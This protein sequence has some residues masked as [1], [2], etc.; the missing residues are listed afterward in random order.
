MKKILC[1][2]DIEEYSSITQYISNLETIKTLYR[3]YAQEIM[4][5]EDADFCVN[6]ENELRILISEFW[7]IITSK[8]NIPFYPINSMKISAETCEVYVE[9]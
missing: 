5:E 2:L 3:I 8:Y 9:E 4:S 7:E 6:K 1:K